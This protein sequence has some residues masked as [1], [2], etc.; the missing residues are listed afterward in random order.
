M[1]FIFG[2]WYLF[3]C[4]VHISLQL[5]A[6]I[7]K[8]RN[9]VWVNGSMEVVCFSCS[10]QKEPNAGGGLSVR[11]MNVLSGCVCVCVCVFHC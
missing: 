4:N 9:T 1:V 3:F 5:F 2:L 6:H 10:T 7:N 11:E 8:L